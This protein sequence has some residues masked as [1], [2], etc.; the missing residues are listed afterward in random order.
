M[1]SCKGRALELYSQDNLG[2]RPAIESQGQASALLSRS[3]PLW[4]GGFLAFSGF[5]MRRYLEARSSPEREC[6]G[7]SAF[8]YG[9]KQESP[10]EMLAP[11]P[12]LSRLQNGKRDISAG[13]PPSLKDAV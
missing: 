11:Q 3:T 4:R 10:Q 12:G 8:R 7:F 5:P 6:S 1:R 2:A 13:H 9:V